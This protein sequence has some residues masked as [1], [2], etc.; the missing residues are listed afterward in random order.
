MRQFKTTE[1]VKHYLL[2]FDDYT[3]IYWYNNAVISPFQ[4]FSEQAIRDNNENTF[5]DL[6]EVLS[7]EQF[8]KVIRDK[9]TN[10]FEEDRYFCLTGSD[11][12]YII[13]FSSFEEFLKL[14]EADEFCKYLLEQNDDLEALE[15]VSEDIENRRNGKNS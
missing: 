15:S 10:Y 11:K 14:T 2:S 7:P 9:R 6:A 12:P 5:Y 3:L 4:E 8:I 13:S 1:Q